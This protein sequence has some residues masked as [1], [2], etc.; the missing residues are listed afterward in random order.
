ML[1]TSWQKPLLKAL[2]AVVLVAII[3]GAGV[4]QWFL[5]QALALDPVL[6]EIRRDHERIDHLDAEAFSA[7][8]ALTG[9]V[10]VFDVRERDEYAVSHIVG[11]LHVAPS[12]R[13]EEFSQRYGLLIAGRDVVFYCSVGKRSAAFADSVRDGAL[14]NGARAV[15]NLEGG[16]FGWHN[17]QR[18]VVGAAGTATT[19]IHPFDA[20]WQRYLTRQRDIAWAPLQP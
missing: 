16:I 1:K 18:P 4:N 13:H 12:M 8:I 5:G 10:V 20:V 9:Q 11:A 2:V 19:K 15:H 3:L 14:G 6:A 7:M 17:A